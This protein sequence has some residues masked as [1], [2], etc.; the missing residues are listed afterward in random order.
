M[1][2]CFMRKNAFAAAVAATF[3]L[4]SCGAS[5]STGDAAVVEKISDLDQLIASAQEEGSVLLYTSLTEADAKA[6]TENFTKKY[7]VD[8]QLMRLGGTDAAT[9][10]DTET[11]ANA[12]SADLLVLA[13]PT[14]IG[15]IVDKGMAVDMEDTGLYTL[16]EETP[17]HLKAPEIGSAVVQIVNSG[18]AYNTDLV[19]PED[20][21]KSWEDLASDR[22]KDKLIGTPPDASANNLA[23]WGKLHDKFGIDFVKSIGN[24]VSRTYPNLV[25]LHEALSAG[26][27]EIALQS[28]QFFIEAQKAAGKPVEFVNLQP[29]VYPVQ[30]LGI[31]ARAKNPYA[32]RLL[33]YYLMTEEGSGTITNPEEGAFSPYDE[34]LVPED[35]AIVTKEETQ[36]YQDEKENILGAFGK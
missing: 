30:A 13:D 27:G 22:W 36:R 16:L 17:E 11:S 3:L 5:A 20:V 31:S 19:S 34:D 21:P 28:A 12:P 6:L 8:I 4:T 33:S 15:D 32:A 23:V 2:V 35:F 26:D 1:K 24:N 14:Y 29:S 25:P 7:D 9:R 18:I 10:F